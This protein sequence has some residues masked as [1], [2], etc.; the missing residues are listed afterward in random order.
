MLCIG[1]F[2]I[3][4]LVQL[5][6]NCKGVDVIRDTQHL[7]IKQTHILRGITVQTRVAFEDEVSLLDWFFWYELN[8][9]FVF[10]E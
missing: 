10:V 2:C 9:D 6:T 3:Q 1:D 5:T 7:C 4:K 8:A